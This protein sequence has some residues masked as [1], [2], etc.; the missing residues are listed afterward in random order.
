M[1][2]LKWKWWTISISFYEIITFLEQWSFAWTRSNWQSSSKCNVFIHVF[3]TIIVII[4]KYN[5]D[6]DPEALHNWSNIQLYK[7]LSNSNNSWKHQSQTGIYRAETQVR[8]LSSKHTKKDTLN[9]FAPTFLFIRTTCD[10]TSLINCLG[11]DCWC[12]P[13]IALVNEKSHT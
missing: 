5:N 11:A 7:F 2:L 6:I 4:T 3:W 10:G 12:N 1:W 13:T 8:G 9:L